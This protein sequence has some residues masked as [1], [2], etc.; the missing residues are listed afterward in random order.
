[1]WWRAIDHAWRTTFVLTIPTPPP[2]R[3]TLPQRRPPSTPDWIV[4][5]YPQLGHRNFMDDES[6][7]SPLAK[8]TPRVC[9]LC[10]CDATM[11]CEHEIRVP[12]CDAIFKGP[13]S[14]IFRGPTHLL[15][16]PHFSTLQLWSELGNVGRRP[17]AVSEVLLWH[18]VVFPAY[19]RALQGPPDKHRTPRTPSTLSDPPPAANVNCGGWPSGGFGGVVERR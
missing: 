13:I 2:P 7:Q 10:L 19:V 1:M 11:R 9:A 8:V 15:L 16:S 5:P 6:M 3:S 17:S 12:S 14:P 4:S 18:A